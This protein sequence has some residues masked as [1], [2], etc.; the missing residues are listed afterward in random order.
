MQ[1]KKLSFLIIIMI[2]YPY[3]LR[4]ENR[5]MYIGYLKPY[6]RGEAK[7]SFRLDP[8]EEPKIKIGIEKEPIKP[9]NLDL[10]GILYN[11]KEKRAFIN[12]ELYKEGEIVE[13]YRVNKILPDKVIMIKNNTQFELKI[14]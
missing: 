5:V 7:K 10:K 12:E 3:L 13:G 4:S 9:D 1:I 8:T 14:E 11:P 2:L 6:E